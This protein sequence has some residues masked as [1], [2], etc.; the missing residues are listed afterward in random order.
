[1]IVYVEFDKKKMANVN[2]VTIFGDL[3]D[4]LPLCQKDFR[5]NFSQIFTSL[6]PYAKLMFQPCQLKA[7]VTLEGKQFDFMFAQYLYPIRSYIMFLL[8]WLNGFF[9]EKMYRIHV[10][11]MRVQGQCYNFI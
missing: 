7:K 2:F 10:S 9:S 3:F 4:F 8:N 11:V 6:R 1:M 5:F